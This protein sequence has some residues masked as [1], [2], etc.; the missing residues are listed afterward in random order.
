MHWLD[1]TL[2]RLQLREYGTAADCYQAHHGDSNALQELEKPRDFL[3]TQA[4]R[5]IASDDPRL[6]K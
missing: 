2:A 4:G 3:L 5:R 6:S 1:A